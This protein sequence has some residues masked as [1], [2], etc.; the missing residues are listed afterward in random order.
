MNL[1]LIVFKFEFTAVAGDDAKRALMSWTEQ[2]EMLF[3]WFICQK[4]SPPRDETVSTGVRSA[5]DLCDYII[6]RFVISPFNTP[7]T[8]GLAL[9]FWLSRLSKSLSIQGQNN[10]AY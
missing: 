3:Y 5:V 2:S 9:A 4:N 1:S 6:S 7:P 10:A 8:N